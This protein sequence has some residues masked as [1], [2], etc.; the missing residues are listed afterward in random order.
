MG[1]I[2]ST[3]NSTISFINGIGSSQ[4]SAMASELGYAAQVISMILV[5]VVLI[6]MASQTRPM[7][8][9]ESIWLI[10]KLTLVAL[11]MRNWTQFNAVFLAFDQMFEVLGQ[12]MLAASLG[13]SETT[14]FARELDELSFKTSSFANVT[15]GRLNI[16]GSVMNG[17][18]VLLI[19]A[20]GAF[21][22]LALIITK[23][24]LAVLIA[25]API[26]IVA[27]LT[28][29]TKSFFESWLSAVISMMMYPLIL[30]GV[31]ATVLAMGNATISTLDAD[32]DITVGTIIPVVMVVIL[33]IIMVMLSPIILSLISGSIQLGQLASS[34]GG[35]LSRPASMVAGKTAGVGKQAAGGAMGGAMGR[36]TP[37]GA[38]RA[39][40][41]GNYMGGAARGAVADTAS[42]MKNP[43]ANSRDGVNLRA[44]QI[45]RAAERMARLRRK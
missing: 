24:V 27:S 45:N 7:G 1:F 19:G 29:Y 4:Y 10:V 31:F 37:D 23:I 16:L 11:F 22:T 17:L 41:A 18:M 25:V 20:L 34:V 15:A 9:S 32:A 35:V 44:N 40:R 43:V 38:S 28:S 21:A 12:R 13:S 26:A 5:I 14:T 2:E 36:E 33:S 42:F 8:A 30:S 3:Y 6:N 39:S